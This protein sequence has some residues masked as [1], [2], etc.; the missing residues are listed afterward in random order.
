MNHRSN[1]NKAGHYVESP[2]ETWRS[3]WE[4]SIHNLAMDINYG[5]PLNPNNGAAK[6]KQATW[7]AREANNSVEGSAN[8][9]GQEAYGSSSPS[10]ATLGVLQPIH[11]PT[12]FSP[13]HPIQT[14][15]PRLH[16][17]SSFN[18]QSPVRQPRCSISVHCIT[19]GNNQ[20]LQL[21]SPYSPSFGLLLQATA[22]IPGRE[23]PVRQTVPAV[24]P[25]ID[26][27]HHRD[28]C[29][30]VLLFAHCRPS[31]QCAVQPYPYHCDL[32]LWL[33]RHPGTL[34][35]RPVSGSST[36]FCSNR[37]PSTTVANNLLCVLMHVCYQSISQHY[38]LPVT[39]SHSHSCLVFVP[40]ATLIHLH[41]HHTRFQLAGFTC[42]CHTGSQPCVPPA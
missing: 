3:A 15:L 4:G 25:A 6:S 22:T 13:S 10:G 40:R 32:C 8:S 17:P 9:G 23:A 39:S 36:A 35:E 5:V 21:C 31:P 1:D 30:L 2:S 41:T 24:I 16:G 19:H 42:M 20:V 34:S 37:L 11:G 14:D 28:S 29:H 12:Q 33:P 27:L 38:L 18:D 7:T 26:G